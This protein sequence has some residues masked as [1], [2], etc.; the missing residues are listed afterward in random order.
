MQNEII[1]YSTPQGDIK[2]EVFLQDET[3]WLTQK[4]ITHSQDTGKRTAIL[5]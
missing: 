5:P 4:A 2:V 3:V 1:L